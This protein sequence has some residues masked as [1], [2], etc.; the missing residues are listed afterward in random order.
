MLL[1]RGTGGGAAIR[2]DAA[3]ACAIITALLAAV[4]ISPA[5]GARAGA[6]PE[7]TCSDHTVPVRITDPGPDHVLAFPM[8]LN[9]GLTRL[10]D[11]GKT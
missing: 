11:R 1:G 8:A 10:R 2:R 6:L 3:R 7:L 4:A 9:P 5:A